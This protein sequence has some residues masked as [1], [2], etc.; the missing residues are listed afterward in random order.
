MCVPR[1]VFRG[2]CVRY[3]ARLASDLSVEFDSSDRRGTGLPYAI[4]LGNGD[5]S[6]VLACCLHKKLYLRWLFI[7]YGSSFSR[8]SNIAD[9][10]ES[11]SDNF[12]ARSYEAATVYFPSCVRATCMLPKAL[13]TPS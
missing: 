2:P 8:C 10:R 5:V 4:V 13:A 9:D 11:L 3:S 1:F 6:A 7:S 12:V